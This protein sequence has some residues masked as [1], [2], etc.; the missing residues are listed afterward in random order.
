MPGGSSLTRLSEADVYRQVAASRPAA[1]PCTLA[2]PWWS[3]RH[4]NVGTAARLGVDPVKP[5]TLIPVAA[6][7][8]PDLLVEV[9]AVAVL[10]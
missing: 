4:V 5:I 8:E 3:R 2:D 6:L 10:P 7:G 9:D 1:G